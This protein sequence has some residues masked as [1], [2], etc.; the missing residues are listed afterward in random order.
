MILLA[1][2]IAFIMLSRWQTVHLHTTYA[3]PYIGIFHNGQVVYHLGCKATV[4]DVKTV[5]MVIRRHL[6][7]LFL[8]RYR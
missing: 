3:H 4:I 6:S 7:G 8:P 5:D 2:I 1:A